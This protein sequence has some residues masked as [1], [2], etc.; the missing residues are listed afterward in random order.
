ME[1]IHKSITMFENTKTSI[2]RQYAKTSVMDVY[3]ISRSEL[4]HSA[5]LK[6]LFSNE[7]TRKVA[8]EKFLVCL[9][10]CMD[11]CCNIELPSDES[12]YLKFRN[13]SLI[14]NITAKTEQYVETKES[15]GRVDLEITA[16]IE[17]KGYKRLLICVE[18]K[19]DSREHG[20]QTS[21]YESYYTNAKKDDELILFV[22]LA[23]IPTWQMFSQ[24][25]ASICASKKFI[26]LN[27]QTLYNEVFSQINSDDNHVNR[28][29][30]EYCN[31]L[32]NL[33]VGLKHKP[34]AIAE[35]EHEAL[36]KFWNENHRFFLYVADLLASAENDEAE[37]KQLKG[38]AD[39]IKEVGR[40]GKF[41][42]VDEFGNRGTAKSKRKILEEYL[43]LY[44]CDK[45]DYKM[46][47]LNKE[48]R[49]KCVI[50]A[51]E[52][53][54]SKSADRYKEINGTGYYFKNEIG[55]EHWDN[56]CKFIKDNPVKGIHYIESL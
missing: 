23:P 33:D 14:G 38:I 52:Y 28:I 32:I 4:S 41:V 16:D 12:E 8:L 29:I 26:L 25:R 15:H 18:N 44:F 50:T 6:W 37:A 9:S 49:P 19:V 43:S 3:G 47:K 56:L 2:I 55:G 24:E 40:Y 21:V 17:W 53:S 11:K 46:K 10:L 20:N 22:F 51:N 45:Y 5:F 13:F 30:K 27:Y 42:I 35:K 36:T 1:S 31:S 34:L 48:V 7:A 39:K 54:K